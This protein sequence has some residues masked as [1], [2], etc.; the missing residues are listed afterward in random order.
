MDKYLPIGSVVLLKNGREIS[1]NSMILRSLLMSTIATVALYGSEGKEA[2][3]IAIIIL[4]A[5]AIFF[6]MFNSGISIKKFSD[7][8]L[9]FFISLLIVFVSV[10]III[11]MENLAIRDIVAIELVFSI[12]FFVLFEILC[13][14]WQDSLMR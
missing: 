2:S 11:Y 13:K 12:I 9:M 3:V 4:S 1:M 5:G 14:K 10:S 8:L 6:A 7:E